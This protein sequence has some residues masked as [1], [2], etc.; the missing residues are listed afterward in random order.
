MSGPKVALYLRLSRDDGDREES[1]SIANQRSFLLD[2]AARQ[3]LTV[4][5]IYIDDGYT[6]TNFDRPGFQR[7]LGD[8]QGGKIN[9]VVTKDLSRLGRDV[10]GTMH[11]Y[12]R[13]FPQMGVRYISVG[14]GIDTAAPNGMSQVMPFLAA[15][16]DFY[17]ADISRKVRAALSI[18]K[19]GGLFI[20]AQAPLGYQ[21][22]PALKGHL[23]PDERTA[24]VVRQIFQDYLAVGSVIGVAKRLTEQEVPTPSQLKGTAQ[25]RFPGAWS[26]T[27]VRRILTNPT[28]AGH[29][30]QNRSQKINYKVEARRQLPREEWVTI[31][32][33]HEPLVSQ[34]NF[35]Q[36]QEL[37]RVRGYAP[38]ARGKGHLLTGLAF[39]A[40]CGAPMTY[41]RESDTR[42]Y[43]VCQ[44]YRRGGRLRLCSSHCVREDAV[45]E[46][47][48]RELRQ[49]SLTLDTEA[50]T[51]GLDVEPERR[52]LLHQMDLAQKQL[53]DC[54]TVGRSAYADKATGVL[55]PREFEEINGAVRRD[56][57]RLERYLSECEA[58]LAGEREAGEWEARVQELIRF[59]RLDRAVLTVL[60]ERVVIHEGKEVELHFRFR[61]PQSVS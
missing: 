24:P 43:M 17:T 23:I 14:E 40:D 18:R 53:E 49:L 11:Y 59:E 9:T 57:E 10:I 25:V 16:N 36:V 12:Q 47:I 58:L 50:L 5:D 35:D 54:K 3:D 22:D 55:T 60:V 42:T 27:M 21:K 61:R 20:G 56:R 44:G 8:I 41:V 26:D 45:V 4:A 31:P 33:T 37:L 34:S 51:E 32:N 28:Y 15:A 2:Y 13:Y 38:Q 30:T 6:G 7:L 52:R 19:Q 48:R 39:C 1:M 29:L 46:A